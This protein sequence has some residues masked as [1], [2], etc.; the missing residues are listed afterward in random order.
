MGKNVVMVSIVGTSEDS[1]VVARDRLVKRHLIAGLSYNECTTTYWAGGQIMCG[2]SKIIRGITFYDKI[3][4]I[5]GALPD[6][7][8]IISAC[9]ST[10]VN[11]KTEKWLNESIR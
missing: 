4:E 1:L 5:E 3:K 2:Q 6:G 9:P 8:T 10:Y 11:P 7:V